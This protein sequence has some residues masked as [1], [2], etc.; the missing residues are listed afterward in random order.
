VRSLAMGC[1]YNNRAAA[2]CNDPLHGGKSH[3]RPI[4]TRFGAKERVLGKT[5]ITWGSMDSNSV[6]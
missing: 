1:F 2:R 6:M 4:Y 5:P 3:P